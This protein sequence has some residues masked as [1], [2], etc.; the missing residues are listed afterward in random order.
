MRLLLLAIFSLLTIA[1]H[2]QYKD[3]PAATDDTYGYK[4]SN[5]LRMKKGDAAKSI[6]YTQSFFSTLQTAAGDSL[7]LIGRKTVHNPGYN[8]QNIANQVQTRA[9]MPISGDLGLV[10]QYTFRTIP[11]NDTIHIYVSIYRRSKLYIPV[12][13]KLKEGK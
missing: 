12:G 5:P 6:K 8:P 3:A 4:S 1:A 9:G 11:G 7:A 13:L 10:D 2:A